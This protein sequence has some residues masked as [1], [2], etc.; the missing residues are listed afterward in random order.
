VAP[1]ASLPQEGGK[2]GG[3]PLSREYPGIP[4]SKIIT[5]SHGPTRTKYGFLTHFSAR[6]GVCL[7]GKIES[8]VKR[9]YVTPSVDIYFLSYS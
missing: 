3:R 7:T 8:D 5:D 4:N 1:A 9:L 6:I 2:T